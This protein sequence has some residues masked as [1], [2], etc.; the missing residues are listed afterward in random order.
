ML[1]VS[2]LHPEMTL[3]ELSVLLN[4]DLRGQ[5]STAYDLALVTLTLAK[6]ATFE[7]S[8]QHLASCPKTLRR[9]FSQGVRMYTGDSL[10]QEKQHH[11]DSS[12]LADLHLLAKE[13]KVDA[14]Q[15]LSSLLRYGNPLTRVKTV[16][17]DIRALVVHQCRITNPTGLFVRLMRT[18]ENAML[19]ARV[20]AKREQHAPE[21]VHLPPPLGSWVQYSGDWLRV[22]EHLGAKVRLYAPEGYRFHDHVPGADT[23]VPLSVA[24]GLL[25]RD[26]GEPL[27]SLPTPEPAR[28]TLKT[29]GFLAMMATCLGKELAGG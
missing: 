25:I 15:V 13:A 10:E 1:N 6:L 16:L 26:R 14:K 23:D 4:D 7:H 17:E 3:R 12:E 28:V 11:L 20:T 24:A 21:A 29:R 9:I 18:G 19:P 8:V 5:K 27:A 22:E 2:N